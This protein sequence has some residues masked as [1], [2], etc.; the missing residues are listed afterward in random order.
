M[1]KYGIIEKEL[2]TKIYIL[3]N[4]LEES[5]HSPKECVD[6]RWSL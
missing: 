1:S 2:H 5:T 3:S 4:N 6:F